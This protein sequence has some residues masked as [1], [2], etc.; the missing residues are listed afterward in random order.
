MA[1]LCFTMLADVKEQH[2]LC[3]HGRFQEEGDRGGVGGALTSASE[4]DINRANC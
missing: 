2:R 1:E 4:A 3:W